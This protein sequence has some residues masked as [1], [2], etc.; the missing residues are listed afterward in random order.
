MGRGSGSE[1]SGFILQK[2]LNALFTIRPMSRMQLQIDLNRSLTGLLGIGPNP[3]AFAA[4]MNIRFAQPSDE[5]LIVGVCHRAFFDEDL[6]GRVIHPH[7]HE[8]P[9]DVKIF[10]HEAAREAWSNPRN[11]TV[12]VTTT[13][14]AQQEK[15]IGVAFWQRQGDD[16][17]AQ[18]VI[19]EWA[20]PGPWPALPSTSNRALDP[21]NKDVLQR[22]APYTKHYWT[23]ANATNWYLSLCAVDPD[24]SGRGAGRLLV[25]WGLDRAEE[26]GNQGECYCER[27]QR[28]ILPEMRI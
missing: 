5:L 15:I 7:R 18:K 10:W 1:H 24:A 17:G 14:D 8:F 11:K 23:G 28:C 25:R 16:T 2:C 6:F 20:D 26:E 9:E 22:S 12:V 27:E 4:I 21:S 19:S 3:I 13:D